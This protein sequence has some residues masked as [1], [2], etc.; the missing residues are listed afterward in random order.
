LLVNSIHRTLSSHLITEQYSP[1][2][3]VSPHHWTLLVNSIHRTLSSPHLIPH[4]MK[5]KKKNFIYVIPVHCFTVSLVGTLCFL[6]LRLLRLLLLNILTN[7]RLLHRIILWLNINIL[8]YLLHLNVNIINNLWD[9]N[10]KLKYIWDLWTLL[11][12]TNIIKPTYTGW[13]DMRKI[14]FD[15]SLCSWYWHTTANNTSL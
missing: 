12:I 3:V 8:N 1:N 13:D 6:M 15:V 4:K 10:I 5:L 11:L 9:L 2:L 14:F 7:N